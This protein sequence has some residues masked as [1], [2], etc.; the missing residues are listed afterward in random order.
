LGLGE[1]E[2]EIKAR[3]LNGK[4]GKRLKWKRWE[5]KGQDGV[6][7]VDGFGFNEEP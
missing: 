3:A 6:V 7:M 1:D 5:G 2:Q 4:D